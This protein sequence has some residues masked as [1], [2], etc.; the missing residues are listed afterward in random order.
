MNYHLNRD[1]QNLGTF[2]LEEL[3]QRREA[4]ELTGHEYVWCSGMANWQRLDA[5]L[6][7]QSAAPT[8][9]SPVAAAPRKSNKVVIALVV[10]GLLV[11]IGGVIAVAVSAKKFMDDVRQIANSGGTQSTSTPDESTLEIASQPIQAG[12]NTLTKER[13]NVI[14]KEFRVRQYLEGYK[15]HGDRSSPHD[16]EIILLI[17]AWINETYDGSAR[18]D[19]PSAR[20]LGNKLA[21]DLT[22]NDAVALLICAITSAELN[23]SIT[24]LE[25]SLLAFE[26]SK[27]PAYPQF[28]AAVSMAT[29]VSDQS[30]RVLAL[31]A[32]AIELFKRALRDGSIQEKDQPQ[33][34][35]ALL[36]GAADAFFTR[37]GT[38]LCDV[39]PELAKRFAWLISVL[40]GEISTR[41][42]WHERGGGYANTVTDKGWREFFKHMAEARAHFTKAWELHPE[43]PQAPALMVSVAMSDAD[44]KD[45]RVWFDRALAAQID[46]EK[47]WS[48]MRW[49]LRPR[50]GGDYESMLALG[51][52]A[53]NSGRFDTDTPRK[54]LDVVTDLESELKVP[55]GKHI[56]GR[57]DIW[58][59]VQRVYE[60]YIEHTKGAAINSYWRS[61]YIAMASQS[62]KYEVARSQLE[63]NN[64]Q[65]STSDLTWWNRDFSL[66]PLEVAA[67]TSPIGQQ[68]GDAEL[69]RN[70]GRHQLALAAYEKL[71]ATAGIDDRTKRFIEHRLASLA[72]EQKL[73]AGEWVDFLPA[74]Q[75]D[76]NWIALRGAHRVLPDG[77]LEVTTTATGHMLF[78]R[79]PTGRDVEVRGEFE[80]ISSTSKSFQAGLVLGMPSLNDQNW[81]AFRLKRNSREGDMVSFARQWSRRQV[82][83]PLTL[84]DK[85]NSFLVRF[86]NGNVAVTV[87]GTPTLAE[88]KP[89]QAIVTYEGDFYVGVGAFN[90]MNETVIRYRNLQ[91]RQLKGKQVAQNEE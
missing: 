19:L 48:S 21:A 89:P 36:T 56:Y 14:A 59:Q 6:Y 37:N 57:K 78:S 83:R 39:E 23:E 41:W 47:A 51:V 71:S 63:A 28:Y 62:G 79:V 30:G 13:L 54:F 33:M 1:G 26:K 88:V 31:D 60:G 87:N 45:M 17:E 15:K 11:F 72:L 73:A 77:S 32:S 24:R 74:K 67:R 46:N 55:A 69:Q 61:M 9:P 22:C 18:T 2:P 44:H 85:S 82:N 76:L 75:G 10:A 91:V 8:V 80:V 65:F 50:W 42:A 70:Q 27:Y 3:R 84:D 40:H 43:W 20:E 49:G 35:D 38:V 81:H 52:T 12:T 4:G 34:A 29:K 86:Q 25:R 64:W 90:D 16:A 5:V 7:P 66:L 53:V 58:P 68:V